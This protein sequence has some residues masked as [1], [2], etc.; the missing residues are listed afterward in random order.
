M[1]EELIARWGYWAVGIGTFFEGESVLVIAGALAQRGLL[2]L[3]IVIGVAFCGSVAGDQFWFFIGRRF[4]RP[5]LVSRP[6]WQAAASSTQGRLARYGDAFV[7][8]FRF[9]Y[10]VRTITPILLGV[11]HYPV[12]RFVALNVAGA[13]VWAAAIGVAGFALGAALTGILQ[14]AA[15]IQAAIAGVLVAALVLWLVWRAR[16]R[17]KLLP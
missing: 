7:L 14:R 15:H 17:R 13:A 10:G 3:P 9:I 8:G 5:L 2:S 4:G 1:L 6:K 11:S 16:Q 12:K